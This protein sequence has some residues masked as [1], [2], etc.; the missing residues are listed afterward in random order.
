MPATNEIRRVITTQQ[1][2]KPDRR[3]L[4]LISDATAKSIN[5]TND[6]SGW[7]RMPTKNCIYA[8]VSVANAKEWNRLNAMMTGSRR[9]DHIKRRQQDLLLCEGELGNDI[10]YNYR[11]N[12]NTLEEDEWSLLS[13]HVDCWRKSTYLPDAP[14]SRTNYDLCTLAD[15][16]VV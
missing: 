2:F 1:W 11:L 7:R 3:R 4:W 5:Y 13:A 12:K 15:E 14:L 6:A 8:A 16:V 9:A 10:W